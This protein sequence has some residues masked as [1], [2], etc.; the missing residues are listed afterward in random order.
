MGFIMGTYRGGGGR[1]GGMG[2]MGVFCRSTQSYIL[3]LIS[4]RFLPCLLRSQTDLR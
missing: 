1:E 2:E 3:S 4:P